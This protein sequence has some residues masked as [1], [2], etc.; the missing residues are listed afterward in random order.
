MKTTLNNIWDKINGYKSII[1]L[2]LWLI[3]RGIKI[4]WPDAIPEEVFE[5]INDI[6]F[7]TGGVGTGHKLQKYLNKN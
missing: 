7:F 3:L 1:S 4:K 6:L 5:W 2:V